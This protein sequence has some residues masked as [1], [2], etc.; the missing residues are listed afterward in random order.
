MKRFLSLALVC[1][2]ALTPTALATEVEENNVAGKLYRQLWA[3]SGFSGTLTLEVNTPTLSTAQPIPFSVDYIYVRPT[4]AET[5]EHRL[6]L[7]L[8]DAAVTALSAQLKDGVLSVMADLLGETWYSLSANEAQAAAS[9]DSGLLSYTGMPALAGVALEWAQALSGQGDAFSEAMDAYATSVDIWIEGFREEAVLGTLA[10]GTS[11]L[12]TSYTVPASAVKEEIKQLLQ[13]LLADAET[14]GA[15]QTLVGEE[16]ATL[17]LNPHLQSFYFEAIDDLPLSGDLTLRRVVSL[18]GNTLE[19]ALSLPLYD[20]EG[21]AATLGYHR[22]DGGD[23]PD[24]N[25]LTLQSE[26]RNMEL[27]YQDYADAAG[28]RVI[29]GAFVNAPAQEGDALAVNFSLN[30]DERES[31][32]EEAREVYDVSATLT[33]APAEEGEG[34]VSF[35]ETEAAFSGHFV[36]RVVRD[37]PTEVT[38]SLDV[39][40]GDTAVSL[41]F[42]G[43]SR[44]RWTPEALPDERVAFFSLSEEDVTALT[45][46]ALTRGAVL[47]LPYFTQPA[48]EAEE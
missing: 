13:T 45:Q 33:L 5:D 42:E 7:T 43:R 17:M 41:A 26:L 11:T 6:D 30:L 28:A 48:E 1:L 8:G 19:L 14:L 3:G 22:A 47:L 31:V 36:S 18:E 29:Q 24:S 38:A 10:D 35:P 9:S 4:D 12:S 25:T 23:A 40:S 21:G 15:L 46:N 44:A 27:T 16:W 2:L 34:Y 37:A 20:A 39:A 32:D